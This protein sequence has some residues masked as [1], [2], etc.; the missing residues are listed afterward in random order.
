MFW[1]I[2]TFAKLFMFSLD[3]YK[4]ALGKDY[5][6]LTFYL[7]LHNEFMAEPESND[8]D[9]HLCTYGFSGRGCSKEAAKPKTLKSPVQVIA[10]DDDK[11]EEEMLKYCPRVLSETPSWTEV[12]GKFP[13]AL[14]V[15]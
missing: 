13:F 6:K 14:L 11:D 8:E 4:A 1:F 15:E 3:S 12:T 10:A 7:I 9:P 5:K 2:L